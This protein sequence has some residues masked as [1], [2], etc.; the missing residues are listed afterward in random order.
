M[1]R[2]LRACASYVVKIVLLFSLVLFSLV[3]YSPLAAS[4]R[5]KEFPRLHTCSVR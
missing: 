2:H 1:Y 3:P 4:K 5:N